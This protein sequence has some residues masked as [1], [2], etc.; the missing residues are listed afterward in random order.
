MVKVDECAV[1][2]VDLAMVGLMVSVA[3]IAAVANVATKFVVTVV[4][5]EQSS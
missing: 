3:I 2:M 5:I 1:Y 4:K